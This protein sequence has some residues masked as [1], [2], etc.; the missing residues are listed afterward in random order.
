MQKRWNILESAPRDFIAGRVVSEESCGQLHEAILHLLWHRG[1]RTE[2]AVAAFLQPVYERDIH[3]PFLFSQMTL[4]VKRI[5]FAL[6]RNERILIFGDYDAD[7]VTS[8]TILI[9]T[10]R[11]IAEKLGSTATIV[12][13]IPHRDREGYGLNGAQ[14]DRFAQEAVNLV[15][16]VDCG[17]AC[18]DEAAALKSHGID[19][20][21]VDH[22]RFGDVLPDAILIHPS[23]PGETYPFKDLAAAGVSWKLASALIIEAR[24]RSL[25]IVDGFEKWLLDLV[26]ISTVADV[27]PL[28]G[29]NRALLS[30]G[31]RV[32]RKTRR[33]G[34]QALIATAGIRPQGISSRDIGFA[35][36][37]RLNAASRM[38]HASIALTLLLSPSREE[39]ETVAHDIEQLNRARQQATIGMMKRADELV[40]ESAEDARIHVLWDEGWSP[41]LVGLVAGRIAERY[42]VPVVAVGKHGDVWIGS[43]RSIPSYDIT[44]AVK[45][46]GDGLLTRV[47][48]HPQACGFSLASDDHL[49]QFAERL[50]RDALDR[51]SSETVGP[52]LTVHAELTLREINWQLI[53]SLARMEPFG[54]GNAEPIFIA[55]ELEVVRSNIVGKDATH[56][57][58]V[59]RSKDGEV[60]SFIAFGFANRASE[61][62]VGSLIDVAFSVAAEDRNGRREIRSKVIDFRESHESRVKSHE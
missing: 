40:A 17:I 29:E 60:S 3:D 47:G 62:A 12:S 9:S 24:G 2:E 31:L 26:A 46:S 28:T 10:L 44:E 53:D 4:A 13:Y 21:I 50:R 7:G 48:G 43:G 59:C 14:V 49:P 11:E 23:V 56:L 38:A 58:L 55:R 18:P 6:E 30:Y 57:R 61:A 36:A 22:H 51:I 15:I 25:S 39:A 33:V 20:I 54:Q 32:L 19:F 34:L 45:R 8:S 37:P 1:I 52:E 16:S 35:I 5:F 41:A 27:V 42:G